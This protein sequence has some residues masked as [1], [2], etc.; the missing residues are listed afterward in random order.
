MGADLLIAR[1]SA[2]YRATERPWSID[3]ADA[4]RIG[5]ERLDAYDFAPW[6]EGDLEDLALNLGVRQWRHPDDQEPEPR[7]VEVEHAELVQDLREALHSALDELA[8]WRRDVAE[9]EFGGR[10][11]WLTGGMSWGDTPTDAYESIAALGW[12]GVYDDPLPEAE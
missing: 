6:G 1:M 4:I 10:P 12:I 9:L 11:Y 2:P 5:H 7:P 3:L 8:G